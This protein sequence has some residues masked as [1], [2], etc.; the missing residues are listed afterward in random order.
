MVQR[1][2]ET[3]VVDYR[4]NPEE[5]PFAWCPYRKKLVAVT[6]S[7]QV[8][9]TVFHIDQTGIY[10]YVNGVNVGAIGKEECPVS[11]D[12]WLRQTF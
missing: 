4:N 10:P 8:M 5:S 9:K 7:V 3:R 11:S 2:V 6:S 12:E 1:D